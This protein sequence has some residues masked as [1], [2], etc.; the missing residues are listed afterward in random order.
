MAL[1]LNYF[2]LASE[3]MQILMSQEGYLRGQFSHSDTVT[4]NTWELVKLRG[5]TGKPM[6]F[7]R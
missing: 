7:L 1:R 5:V 4:T 6:C 2:D 3:A